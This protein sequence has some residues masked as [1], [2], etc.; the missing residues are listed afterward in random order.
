[1]KRKDLFASIIK[2]TILIKKYCTL[3]GNRAFDDRFTMSL[4]CNETNTHYS[5]VEIRD[6]LYGDLLL[7]CMITD[8]IHTHLASYEPGCSLSFSHNHKNSFFISNS[9]GIEL[10][11][12]STAND[13]YEAMMFQMETILTIEESEMYH[14]S[15]CVVPDL[16]DHMEVH[17]KSAMMTMLDGDLMQLEHCLALFVKNYIMMA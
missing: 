16:D 2:N 12:C 10:Q 14:V 17:V 15:N 6:G 4:Q 13:E 8:R 1:M 3:N 9:T 11:F 5:H 7:S